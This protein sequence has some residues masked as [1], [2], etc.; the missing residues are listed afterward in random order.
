VDV[1]GNVIGLL[2]VRKRH[3]K[4]QWWDGSG[5]QREQ[6]LRERWRGAGGRENIFGLKYNVKS[7]MF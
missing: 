2:G 3:Y 4:K 1:V 6:A 5:K 7:C